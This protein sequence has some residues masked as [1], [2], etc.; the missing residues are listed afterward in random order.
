MATKS[1]GSAVFLQ[2]PGLLVIE[3]AKQDTDVGG[4]I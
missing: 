1:L 2:L 4:E 3:S